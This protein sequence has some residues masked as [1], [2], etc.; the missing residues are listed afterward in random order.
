D[1]DG[2]DDCARQSPPRRLTDT[3]RAKAS[4]SGAK[5]RTHGTD[6]STTARSAAP[7]PQILFV[8]LVRPSSSTASPFTLL[9]LA[10]ACARSVKHVSKHTAKHVMELNIL[11]VLSGKKFHRH[12]TW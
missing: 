11:F 9:A 10:S 4:R 5:P 1:C 8:V 3:V 6:C 12:P 2:G 7:P